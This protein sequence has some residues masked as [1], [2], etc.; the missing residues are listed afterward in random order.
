M[1]LGGCLELFFNVFL[2]KRYLGVEL[3]VRC[4]VFGVMVF[5]DVNIEVDDFYDIFL[6]RLNNS[7][8]LLGFDFGLFVN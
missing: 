5:D 8:F 2:E 7:L 3:L 4:V 1:F 6:L